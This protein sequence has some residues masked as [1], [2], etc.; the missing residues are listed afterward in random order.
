M[1][2]ACDRAVAQYSFSFTF[3]LYVYYIGNGYLCTNVNIKQID[4][5]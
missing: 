1:E 2:I 3:V 5:K 4:R